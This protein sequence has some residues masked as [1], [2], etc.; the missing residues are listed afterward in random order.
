MKAVS[1]G[2][3]PTYSAYGI[4]TDICW[5]EPPLQ[6]NGIEDKWIKHIIIHNPMMKVIWIVASLLAQTGVS[7]SGSITEPDGY[8]MENYRAPVPATLRGATVIDAIELYALINDDKHEAALIDVMPLHPKPPDFPAD[9]LWRPP[10]RYN[11]PDSVWLPNVGYG[12]ISPEF[13]EYLITNLKLL[14]ADK[15][16]RR[17][18]FYCAADCWMSWNVAKR[19]LALGFKNVHWFPG[20]TDEWEALG[21]ELTAGE[22][23]E[24]PV[25]TL[26]SDGERYQ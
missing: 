9:R 25:E 24:M 20:G 19:A 1:Y 18:V 2:S 23:V 22:P 7:G 21:Y 11:L 10:T 6:S 3:T 4:R 14:V 15:Q 26:R 13:R 5:H 12:T 17:L 8:R 16:Q